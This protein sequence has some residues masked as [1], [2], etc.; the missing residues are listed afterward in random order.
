MNH[1]IF[2]SCTA[3][4]QSFLAEWVISA[5][6]VANYTG[7]MLVLDYGLERWS[8]KLLYKYDVKTIKSEAI[9]HKSLPLWSSPQYWPV[10]MLTLRFLDMIPIIEKNYSQHII[11]HFDTDIW[12]Q[13]SIDN[14]FELAAQSEGVVYSPDVS[15]HSQKFTPSKD[16]SK[17]KIQIPYEA[18]IKRII[19]NFGST[20]Q[21]GFHCAKSDVLLQKLRGFQKVLSDGTFERDQV[22]QV[23]M[24]WLFDFDKDNANG[25]LYNCIGSD[26]YF[27]NNLWRLQR[28]DEICIGLHLA[29]PHRNHSE[30]QFRNN[31]PSLLQEE[32]KKNNI[33]PVHITPNR[34]IFL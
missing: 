9:G 32:L 19:E 15:W 10:T 2:T 33:D 11:A 24:N 12:F 6:K 29:G 7:E 30:R 5:R 4:M 26:T 22:D 31:F 16:E 27:N 21:G 3:R 13:K 23:I 18:K 20:I 25:Y 8:N 14:L 28:T 17:N 1:L 34:N